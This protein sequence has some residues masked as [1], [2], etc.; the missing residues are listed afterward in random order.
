MGVNTY[1]LCI[2]KAGEPRYAAQTVPLM[3]VVVSLGL[4][5]AMLDLCR[6]T[7]HKIENLVTKEESKTNTWVHL[8]E[9]W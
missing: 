4:K 5:S 9:C 3:L 7:E 8:S 1:K 6:M 2:S